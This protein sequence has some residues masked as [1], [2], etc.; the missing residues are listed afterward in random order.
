MSIPQS[1]GAGGE[2]IYQQVAFTLALDK[3]VYP[4]NETAPS[5]AQA[6][7]VFISTI[8]PPVVLEFFRYSTST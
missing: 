6:N 2:T 4:F 1:Q 8:V 7:L 3:G 5:H